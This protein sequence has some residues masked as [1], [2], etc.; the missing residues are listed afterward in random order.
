[1]LCTIFCLV[2]C[3]FLFFGVTTGHD[4]QG[5]FPVSRCDYVPVSARLQLQLLA[6]L[7]AVP[8]CIVLYCPLYGYCPQ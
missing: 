1:M 3:T 6:R 8:Y 4:I 7:V 2:N 5:C